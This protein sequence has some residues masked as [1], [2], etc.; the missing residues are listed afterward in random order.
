MNS[1]PQPSVGCKHRRPLQNNS[2]CACER[3]AATAQ[4]SPTEQAHQT[5]GRGS[6]SSPRPGLH[7]TSAHPPPSLDLGAQVTPPCLAP[8]QP[9][10]REVW[11]EGGGDGFAGSW[12]CLRPYWV[13][14]HP[15]TSHTNDRVSLSVLFRA[16]ITL[17]LI[18]I[19]IILF[20][21]G[22][23]TPRA[24][25]YCC[26]NSLKPLRLLHVI[27]AMQKAS[28]GYQFPWPISKCQNKQQHFHAVLFLLLSPDLQIE[29]IILSSPS[30][31][32]KAG[33]I[34]LQPFFQELT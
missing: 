14:N 5:A 20:S 22:I 8:C 19:I 30:L 9:S 26:S 32:P 17:F 25:R 24:I 27:F 34:S 18:F 11:A 4:L 10:F 13:T 33:L 2:T 3:A 12:T 21:T 23:E 16:L 31:D 15:R 1:L 29:H 7:P 28:A 6:C